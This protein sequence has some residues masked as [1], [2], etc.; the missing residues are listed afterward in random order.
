M[1]QGSFKLP[2]FLQNKQIAY[3]IY[4]N[5]VSTLQQKNQIKL[6]YKG[7][8][9]VF[10]KNRN[11]LSHC[12]W[13]HRTLYFLQSIHVHNNYLVNIQNT[14]NIHYW[15]EF[16]RH[17][18]YYR[19]IQTVWYPLLDNHYITYCQH[20]KYPHQLICKTTFGGWL[21][22]KSY[23]V[24]RHKLNIVGSVNDTILIHDS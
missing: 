14:T 17:Q 8:T 1:T 6:D 22:M 5:N 7:G 3:T 13:Y 11:F 21:I 19:H 10:R 24:F 12:I 2:I 15:I 20:F 16:L 23:T 9:H 18:C 4:N